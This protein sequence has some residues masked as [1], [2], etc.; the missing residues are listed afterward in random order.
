MKISLILATLNRKDLLIRGIRSVLLQK[1]Q[2]FEIIVIDQ[3][4]EP[5]PDIEKMDDRIRYFYIEKRGLSLARNYG[6]HK[7]TGD[8]IALMDD[9]AEYDYD[10]LTVVNEWFEKNKGTWMV[11][12]KLV[13]PEE[14]DNVRIENRIQRIQWN[15]LMSI[16]SAT[17]FIKKEF[18]E[19][20][21]FDEN[22]GAGRYLGSA[23]E[24]DIVAQMLF[25]KKHIYKLSNL[26]V[27]HKVLKEKTDIDLEKHKSYCR[28][29]GA[30]CAKQIQQNKNIYIMLLYIVSMVR[31]FLGC[32]YAYI[33]NDDF[34]K[35]L[36]RVTL[37]SRQEGFVYYTKN[38]ATKEL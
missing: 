14:K 8:I 1:H 11:A 10:A 7:A 32:C 5:Q 16:C 25:E 27:Y 28:G 20:H 22:L 26:V 23:E 38:N 13:D 12:G 15:T 36:Y 19:N 35:T 37:H 3:S 2:D 33:K 17:M 18:F 6:I 24:S 30:F 4:D 31:T 29:Y 34:L 9:D 21:C